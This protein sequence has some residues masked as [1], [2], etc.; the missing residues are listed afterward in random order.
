LAL[1]NDFH[2]LLIFDLDSPTA[3]ERSCIGLNFFETK[4]TCRAFG[5][6]RVE[7]YWNFLL[8]RRCARV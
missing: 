5:A 1:F 4:L 8:A 3:T 6:L 7:N 2:Y